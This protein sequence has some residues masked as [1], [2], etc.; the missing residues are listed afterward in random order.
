MERR[1]AGHGG[2]GRESR[3]AAALGLPSGEVALTVDALAERAEKPPS[4]R[5]ARQAARW[6]WLWS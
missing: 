4:L 1:A 2:A 5:W 3:Q 6:H